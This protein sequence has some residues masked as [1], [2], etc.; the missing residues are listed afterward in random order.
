[1][2]SDPDTQPDVDRAPEPALLLVD[3]GPVAAHAEHLHAGDVE[4]PG[5]GRVDLD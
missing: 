2:S 1:M 4:G 5:W 3:V